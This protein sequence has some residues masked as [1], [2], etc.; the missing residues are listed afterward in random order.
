[1]AHRTLVIE[2]LPDDDPYLDEDAVFGVREDL[3]MKYRECREHGEAPADLE[4]RNRL[5]TPYYKVDFDF[6]LA[7]A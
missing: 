5:T 2:L 4:A 1:M 6:Q 7:K 3:T